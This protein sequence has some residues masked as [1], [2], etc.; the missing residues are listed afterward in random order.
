MKKTVLLLLTI[1]VFL[2]ACSTQNSVA[3][4]ST[5][6]QKEKVVVVKSNTNGSIL[7][8]GRYGKWYKINTRLEEG[9][10]YDVTL[11]IPIQREKTTIISASLTDFTPGDYL[12]RDIM[13][14]YLMAYH[15]I[16]TKEST[17]TKS[18]E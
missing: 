1:S 2:T 12:Q 13:A 4:D 7:A 9:L 17:L 5:K 16:N 10:T 18:K 3:N 14:K 11:E 8:T 15:Q 6:T